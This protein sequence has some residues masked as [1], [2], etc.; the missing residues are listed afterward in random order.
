MQFPFPE[1]SLFFVI[2]PGFFFRFFSGN[3][4]GFIPELIPGVF[5]NFL[6]GFVSEAFQDFSRRISSIVFY[7]LY[8]F[9]PSLGGIF[10]GVFFNCPSRAICQRFSKDFHQISQEIFTT[11]FLYKFFARSIRGFFPGFH[12]VAFLGFL[13]DYFAEFEPEFLLASGSSWGFSRSLLRE[14]IQFFF[15]NFTQSS[16]QD[17]PWNL[18]NL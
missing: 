1:G 11:K 9:R 15:Q 8:F 12:L 7:F 10:P 13:P 2:L 5:Q 14:F 4:S 3:F 6:Y 17:F 18:G 16:F